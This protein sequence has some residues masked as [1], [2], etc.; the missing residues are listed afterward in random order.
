M[1]SVDEYLASVEEP[2]RSMLAKMRGLIRAVLPAG[3]TE[4]I[5]YR[6]PAFKTSKVLVWFA[7]FSNH[8]SLFPTAAPIEALKEELKGHVVSKGT[9]QFPLDKP[10]P[11]ALIKKVVKT[12]LEQSE[13]KKPG[14]SMKKNIAAKKGK[15]A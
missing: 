7:A 6:M 2:A 10:L 12:R 4:V 11:A 5:S 15:R 8:C 13:G 3:A 14:G 9:I 1:A